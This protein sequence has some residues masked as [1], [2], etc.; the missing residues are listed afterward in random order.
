MDYLHLLLTIES[1][2]PIFICSQVMSKLDFAPNLYIK[3]VELI[4][5]LYEEVA[6]KLEISY[7]N[8]TYPLLRY[9]DKFQE[10]VPLFVLNVNEF[11]KEMETNKISSQN[12]KKEIIDQRRLKQELKDDLPP[13]IVIG[14]FYINVD[15][16]KQHL[17]A[18]RTEIVKK[19]FDYYVDRMNTT[20]EELLE[21]FTI[22]FNK[23]T[24]RPLSI[25]HLLEIQEFIKAV[26]DRVEILQERVKI[27]MLEYE[28][29]DYFWYNLSDT[30][31]AMK[32]DVF[33]WPHQIFVKVFNVKEEHKNDIEEF[34]KQQISEVSGFQER[35]ESLNEEVQNFSLQFNV[36]KAVEYSVKIK[37]QW[38][39]INEIQQYGE[40]LKKRQLIFEMDDLSLEFLE[41]II[42]SFEPYRNLWLACADFIKHEDATLGNP[43]V[44]LEI[45]DVFKVLEE[46]DQTLKSCVEVFAEKPEIADCAEAFIKRIEEFKPVVELIE[47]VKHPC[48]LVMHWQELS[49]K[50]GIEIKFSMSMNFLYCMKKG[51]MEHYDLVKDIGKRSIEEADAIQ[52][53][54]EE[55]ERRKHEEEEFRLA[56]R[57]ARKCRTDIM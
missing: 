31:F 37:N 45:E 3:T 42:G 14:P 56:K 51:I 22:I 18:K 35:L 50:A 54:I 47:T 39:I 7:Q 2:V 40:L 33:G 32:W 25:E 15:P 10:Y 48:W 11:I 53:A 49:T 21:E 46:L 34:K 12:V 5:S 29:L 43:I 55:E 19:I 27:M 36:N 44:G 17:I 26:P 23:I 4:E 6:G 28:V 52:R 41:S 16:L 9:A 24:E 30:Q 1:K 8:G 20:T 57:A 38:K 13:S